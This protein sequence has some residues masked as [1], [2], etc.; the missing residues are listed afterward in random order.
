MEFTEEK[1]QIL[2]PERRLVVKIVATVPSNVGV[3]KHHA[4]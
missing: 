4:I 2:V 3:E 1:K